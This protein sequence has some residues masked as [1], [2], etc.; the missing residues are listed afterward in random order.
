MAARVFV[1][2]TSV[3]P[4]SVFIYN[5]GLEYLAL[6][7]FDLNDVTDSSYFPMKDLDKDTDSDNNKVSRVRDLP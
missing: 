5:H 6:D 7:K 3:Q 2:I 1:L 4:L